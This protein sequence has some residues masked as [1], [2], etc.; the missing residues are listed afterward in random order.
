M[1]S[2]SVCFVLIRSMKLGKYRGRVTAF[3]LKTIFK[4]LRTNQKVTA[5][6]VVRGQKK[7]HLS[8][9]LLLSSI[10]MF[11]PPLATS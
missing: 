5:P 1:F 10:I 4:V 2:V 9:L 6:A 8:C 3:P 7:S 11:Q